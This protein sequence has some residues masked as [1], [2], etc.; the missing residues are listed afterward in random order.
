MNPPEVFIVE[1][2]LTARNILTATL[3]LEGY[4]VASFYDGNALLAAIRKCRPSFIVLD[5][6]LPEGSGLEILRDVRE[7]CPSIPV[8]MISGQGTID[9]AVD[10]LKDGASDFVQKPFRPRDLM[11]RINSA[12]AR[13]TAIAAALPRIDLPSIP[14]GQPLLTGRE[15][16]ILAHT[17]LGKSAKETSRM[18]GISHRTVEDHRSNIMKKTGSTSLIAAFRAMAGPAAFDQLVAAIVG[19]APETVLR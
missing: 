4:K 11:K 1:D 3:A 15:R 8:L 10:A 16:E 5:V 2:D 9:M 18:Y 13:K 14:P 6:F 17:L 7:L 19:G 12:L